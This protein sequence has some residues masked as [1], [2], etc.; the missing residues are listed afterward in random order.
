MALA[1]D[2]DVVWAGGRDGV[3]SVSQATGEVIEEL[4]CDRRLDYVRDILVDTQGTLWVAHDDGLS[5]R[6][7]TGCRTLDEADGLPSH[8][9][10]AL[11][12][13]GLG[14]LW[15]GTARGAAVASDGR[16]WT[17]YTTANGLAD[18]MVNV[19]LADSAGGMW[20]G[21]YSAPR[22]GISRYADG[23]WQAITPREG[24][25]HANVTDIVEARDG[26]VWV[27]TG[28]FDRGG[29]ARLENAGGSWRVTEVLT[30]DDGLA[31]DKVR[32]VYQTADGVLWFG[33]EYD[34]LTRVTAAG[35][36]V[37][38]VENGLPHREVKCLAEN[39]DGTLWIG[40]RDGLARVEARAL[41]ALT[42]AAGDDDPRR[43]TKQ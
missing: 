5:R 42:A 37:L 31:G 13:D 2:G 29:A 16:D 43:T 30:P 39:R 19:I 7:G 10:N 21:S 20:F 4:D 18:D 8:R 24:L 27:G 33:S 34:G 23:K 22:G 36:Q 1:F 3:V 12:I 17:V 15:V 28:L 32:S 38:G 9:V 40:T 11:E 6:D 26:T 25:P 14:R 41:A 35:T